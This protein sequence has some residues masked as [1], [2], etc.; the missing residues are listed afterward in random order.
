MVAISCDC[1]CWWWFLAIFCVSFPLGGCFLW[2]LLVVSL[3][4]A[5]A[6]GWWRGG[7]KVAGFMWL[8]LLWFLGLV[9]MVIGMD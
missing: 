1:G 9:V 2:L 7:G 8:F 4:V 3:V 5:V 6:A